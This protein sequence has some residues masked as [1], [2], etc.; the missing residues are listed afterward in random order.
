MKCPGLYLFIL[1]KQQDHQYTPI[2]RINTNDESQFVI[3]VYW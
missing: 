2:K 1:I 3:G